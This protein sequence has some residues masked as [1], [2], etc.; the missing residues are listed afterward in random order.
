MSTVTPGS[1]RDAPAAVRS[2]GRGQRVV[3][4]RA[5]GEG[6][7]PHVIERVDERHG[8][9]SAAAAIGDRLG[10][11][12]DSVADGI[13]VQDR[14]GRVVYANNAAASILGFADRAGVI[15]ASPSEIVARFEIFDESG[16]PL[17]VSALPGRLALR[18]IAE[19]VATVRFRV[20]ATG[21]EHWAQVRATPL[22]DET[23]ETSF[24]IN[25]FHDITDRVRMEAGIRAG[26]ARYRQLVEAMPQIAWATDAS[27]AL[28]MVNDRATE[29]T[30]TQRELQVGLEVDETIH[31][32]DRARLG[33]VWSASLATGAPLETACRIRRYD[34]A[35]RWHLLRA[36]PVRADDGSITGWIGTSTD[37]DDARQA[38][39]SLRLV[40][41]A[42]I[43][44]DATLDLAEIVDAAAETVVPALADWCF[45]DLL[46]DGGGV[47]RM[48]LATA[49]RGL[50][51]LVERLR[52]F[53][54]EL[55]G[56][57]PVAKALRDG[58]AVVI[59]DVA[60]D[61]VETIA[62]TPE[63]ADLL[64]AVAPRSVIVVPLVAHARTVGVML[65]V[66]TR[67]G[68]R[69]GARD[70]ATAADLA[71][72]VALAI[73]NA[74]LYA[75]EQRAR[76]AAEDAAD[77]T[78]RLQR[79]T[80]ALS[81]ATR[82]DEVMEIILRETCEAT[83]A[84]GGAIVIAAG[85]E[86]RFEAA[87][88]VRPEALDRFAKMPLDSDHPMARAIRTGEAEWV[89][90]VEQSRLRPLLE[91]LPGNP[92]AAACAVPFGGTTP[93]GSLGLAFDG[94][95]A[96]TAADRS[97][98]IAQADLCSQALE[99]V[100]LSESR[101]ELLRS[102][103]DQRSRLET[104]LRQMPA[105]VLI[106]DAEGTL[107]LSNAEA[108]N[109]WRAPIAPGRP[110]DDYTEYVARR[111][112]GE[113]Y[114]VHEWPL[115]RALSRGET[116]T[117]EQM[118]IVRFD[119]SP[120]WISVDAA[121]V[122][123]RD[124]RIVAAVS[125]F[126]DITETRM[127]Q[128]RQRFLA[129]ASALLA[130][131]LDYDVTIQRLA[132]LAVP[133]I[134][135]WCAIDLVGPD[136]EPERPAIAHVDPDKV[137]LAR[138]LR[139]R[140]PSPPDAPTG[141]PAVIRTG[142]S[143]FVADISPE[144]FAAIEDPALREIMEQLELRS[145][146]CVPLTARGKTLGA[147]TFIGAESGRRFTPDDLA[148]AES[149]AGRAASAVQNAQLFAEVG[150]FKRILD[151]TLDAVFMFDP[152]TLAFSYVNHG[153]VDQTGY[154]E[155]L[156]RG[157]NPTMLTVDLDEPQLR[158]I[159]AP[160]LEGRLESRTV[161]LTLRHR[162]GKRLPVEMLLQHIVLPGDPGRIVATARDISDRIEAQARLQRLAEAEH[163]R[164]AELN[165]VIRAM[166]EGVVV[167]RGDGTI[168]LA[169]PA[170]EELLPEASAGTYARLLAAF[171]DGPERG[172]ALKTRGG[173][174]ELRVT[175]EEDR[176]VE[177]ST[178]P[179]TARAGEREHRDTETIVLLRDVTAA[180]QRQAIRDTF[181]GVLSHELRTPV[182]TI[183][184]GSK[185]LARS[186]STLDE[187][188]RRS[189]FED[190][191]VEAE[192]LHRLVE[193]VIALTRFGEEESDIGDEP[194]LLQRILPGVVRS[195]EV[196]WPG[197]DFTLRVPGG[198]PTVTADAT[199]V[200]QVVRNLLS[201]AAKYGGPGA[202]VDALVEAADDEVLVRILDD[203]PGFPAGEADRLFELY[204]RSPSTAGSASGAG[205]GLFVCARL[206]RAM[207]G[208]I[209][210]TPRAG[211]GSEFG[212]S[213][214]VMA[215]G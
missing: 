5:V 116:I 44:L 48:G 7:P 24:A 14:T 100:G 55:T 198:I 136:G 173:P 167:C 201:N 115:A 20:V 49:D 81:A 205:I 128:D 162:S 151:A 126:S 158:S 200:E 159:I 22:L 133:G 43:R 56:P 29:Y 61:F 188:V 77:R 86:L 69:Y 41:E 139:S 97:F 70:L 118:A 211:R 12:L 135:D 143:E 107:V 150:R 140:F 17:P 138:E 3:G 19:P 208:R 172:P 182:T 1:A 96:F 204:Y 110:I 189:L 95:R 75:A 155:E 51:P 161:T 210:A 23:G 156:L 16:A 34:G 58:E 28:T 90:D 60:G 197:V 11:V 153:A 119:G 31:P 164:A 193:D 102:L 64:R 215:E 6:P 168:A 165:A 142:Q 202:H 27:G 92:P 194:V 88:N 186:S 18:G 85:D 145:Y 130:S 192:R 106:S 152:V 33:A 212:F 72:R 129:D 179:V 170:A 91:G 99:R 144:A 169:N 149:L 166:G 103:E 178:Y 38:E 122:R 9:S 157:M 98:V 124:G 196:R 47:T 35:F 82:R 62:R 191:H 73:S 177:L 190:I 46:D 57:S 53:P 154:D 78:N 108:S 132:E 65:L 163:A 68:R 184:A 185:V 15:A 111:P 131:S 113:P 114:A 30:G 59:P 80:R 39:D 94:R 36:V 45:V 123:D 89:E 195:E 141:T 147:I 105:G 10:A 137:E 146:M 109:I 203:G 93:G 180:R 13:T 52:E 4:A 76:V 160:L 50:E 54:T 199:Y 127:A 175:G 121:P 74:E 117:G 174:I 40:A 25:T 125:T 104:V 120:G 21:A 79:T 207:G 187:E 71:R 214:K 206:I 176:W 183:F 67:S 2:S 37:I 101:E 209:W 112:T 32:A 8:Q 26:E 42:T 63:H 148:L 84:H 181:I 134:A 87:R 213:L 83:G 171:D 66:A